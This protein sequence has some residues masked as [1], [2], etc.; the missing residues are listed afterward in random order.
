MKRTRTG[1]YFITTAPGEKV[2]AFIPFPL[3]PKPSIHISAKLLALLEKAS[4]TIGKLDSLSMNMP[5]SSIILYQYIRKEAVL[6]SQIEGTQSSLSDL[7]KF[8][9][10]ELPGVPLYDVQEVSNYVAAINHG[11][12][13]IRSDNFPVS[14]RLLKE[15]HKILLSHGRGA[16]KDPGEFRRSQN[17]IGGTRPGNA[18][19]VPAPPHEVVECMSNLEKFIHDKSYYIP[20][21]FKAAMIHVQFETIHPF[22]DGNG[23][24]GR[25]FITLYLCSE[26]ILH[27]PVLYLSLYLKKYQKE[28]YD[29][30]QEV[31]LN[32]NWEK[33]IMF[34]L[35]GI[36]VT[37]GEAV[38]TAKAIKK[39]YDKDSKKISAAG[40]SAGSLIRTHQNLMKKLIVTP[41][42]IA[43]ELNMSF[44]TVQ[45]AL[46][47]LEQL[48]IVREITGRKRNK[49]YAYEKALAVLERGVGINLF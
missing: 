48:G 6:S 11:L 18:V 44:P 19:F 2:K 13:R 21:L 7:L 39:L 31:R 38:E 27:E 45:S 42:R 40:K 28:Y 4:L 34:F 23:R 14:I 46:Q 3:P 25:L 9:N 15:I 36:C 37:A 47:R 8:E 30:L 17:W 43:Q 20:I 26:K 24:I 12:K 16:H 41:T 22:L 10:D 33:W 29:L 49:M 5:D 32:G 1:E 35:K